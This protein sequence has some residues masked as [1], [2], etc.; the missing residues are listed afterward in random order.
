MWP[1][2]GD[3]DG[4][5]TF[6]KSAGDLN[7]LVHYLFNNPLLRTIRWNIVIATSTRIGLYRSG[8][9]VYFLLIP[10]GSTLFL[11]SDLSWIIF[12]CWDSFCFLG[13]F[14]F[15]LHGLISPFFDWIYAGDAIGYTDLYKQYARA[16]ER[17]LDANFNHSELRLIKQL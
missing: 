12:C 7:C 4:E 13:L 14:S 15:F 10:R 8:E 16:W 9:T 1:A 6:R 3:L 11:P 17:A 5:R 2:A